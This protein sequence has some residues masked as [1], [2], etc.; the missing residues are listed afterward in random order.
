MP[1]AHKSPWMF[2]K[3][4]KTFTQAVY[5]VSSTEYT[6]TWL[7]LKVETTKSDLE[8]TSNRKSRKILFKTRSNH[9]YLGTK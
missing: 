8:S 9:R 7:R 2:A 4:P 5:I 1:S 6:I 3:N